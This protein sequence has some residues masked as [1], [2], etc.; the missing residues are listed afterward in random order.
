MKI[1]IILGHPD[2]KS[3]NHAIAR[4]VR[5][6]LLELGCEVIFHDLYEENFPPLLPAEEIP[7]TGK[8]AAIVEKYCKELVE[9]DGIVVVHPNWWGQPPAV[10]KGWIDRVIRPG[11]AYRFEEGDDGEGAPTGLLKASAAVVFNTGN[12]PPARETEIFGDPLDAIWRRCIFGLCGVN[13]FHRKL[14][15]VIVTS[16]EEQRARWLEEARELCRTAFL[17]H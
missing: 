9:A 15:S 3:F 6:G 11:T 13:D 4:T 8:V 10:L 2:S 16:S 14:F 1:L 12:T 7:A 17:K 5:D